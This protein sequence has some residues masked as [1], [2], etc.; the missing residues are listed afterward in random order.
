MFT[1][2][3]MK[4]FLKNISGNG[5]NGFHLLEN[6]FALARIRSVFKKWFPLISVTV[7]ASRKELSSKIDGF[8]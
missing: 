8:H 2:A 1:L 5:K 4:N 6:K 7:S 3:G